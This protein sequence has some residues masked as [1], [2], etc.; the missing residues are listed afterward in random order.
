MK[1]ALAIGLPVV[2]LLVALV[3]LL[4][5]NT[6]LQQETQVMCY[7]PTDR[8]VN[9]DHTV[10]VEGKLVN[11]P[12]LKD[13]LKAEVTLKQVGY[14]TIYEV[15]EAY[16]TLG[17]AYDDQDIHMVYGQ[18]EA[19]NTCVFFFNEDLSL[20]LLY[21]SNKEG[22]TYITAEEESDFIDF[23]NFCATQTDGILPALDVED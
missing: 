12:V 18:S 8:F 21:D 10:S 5:Y 14:H 6:E 9:R 22:N 11:N 13:K 1:K 17:E 2:L 7:S 4:P 23:Y 16:T 15:D 19:M 20:F 3:L